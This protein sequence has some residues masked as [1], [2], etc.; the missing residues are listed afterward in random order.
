MAAVFL[1]GPVA[2]ACNG[3][4]STVIDA[5]YP[6]GD[7]VPENL[8]RFYL[9]FSA[10][11]AAED[12]LSSVRLRDS[13]GQNVEGV[14]LSNRFDLW[15]P[16]RTRLT[17]LLD[18]GRVKTGL[19][20]HNELGRALIAGEHYELTIDTGLIDYDQCNLAEDYVH[21][22]EATLEDTSAPDPAQWQIETPASGSRDPVSIDLGTPHDHLSMAFR[23][24]VRDTNGDTVRG[25]VRLTDHEAG[26]QFKPEAPWDVQR[27]T[28][29]I[30]EEF[31]DLAGN[32]PGRTFD[33][34]V[35][36]RLPQPSL[37]RSFQPKSGS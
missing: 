24:R 17:L 32:R 33:Q 26:W 28:I 36:Q 37:V 6:S 29:S 11:M 20:A 16:D 30:G 1:S 2:H 9:Y 31:E 4:G 13:D 22:F 19:D 5:I 34:P 7:E 12:V 3:P 23:V 14:F 27:Y 10:P 21:R 8:L 15:S 25:Q 18:P 35:G